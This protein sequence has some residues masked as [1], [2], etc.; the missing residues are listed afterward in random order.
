ME[1]HTQNNINNYNNYNNN[2]YDNNNNYKLSLDINYPKNNRYNTQENHNENHIEKEFYKSNEP[3]TLDKHNIITPSRKKTNDFIPLS[4]RSS[5]PYIAKVI[6]ENIRSAKDC[7]YLLEQYFQNQ[8]KETRYK[9]SNEQ[10]KLIFSF[11]DERTAFD[12]T[13][14]I[15]NEKTKNDLFRNV[16][17]HMK[18]F[19]NKLYLKKQKMEKYKKGL[20]LD[21]IKELVNG[22]CSRREKKI[23]KIKIKGVIDFGL[24]SP[25][26]N[27]Y[28][29]H[30]KLN[31]FKTIKNKNNISR[32]DNYKD[33][34]G[35]DGYNGLPLKSYNNSRINVLNTH[36]SV[37]NSIIVREENKKKWLSPSNFN[38]Y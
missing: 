37:F 12:F 11:D 7:L 19:P 34:N 4:T 30:K 28:D 2:N 16:V 20:S 31:S 18:L 25:F 6:L 10:D 23:H 3:E 26:P 17:V 22:T 5:N 38:F 14:I 36:Y 24:K 27:P 33:I 35:Y 21:R 29:R 15:Y 9:I 1:T 8:G 13:K 32:N